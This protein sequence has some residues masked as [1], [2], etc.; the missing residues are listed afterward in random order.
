MSIGNPSEAHIITR[1]ICARC[2]GAVE[3]RDRLLADP[4][5]YRQLRERWLVSRLMKPE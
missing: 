3:E 2:V 1:D 5:L 4:E